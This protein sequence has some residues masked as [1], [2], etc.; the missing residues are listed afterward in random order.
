M[1]QGSTDVFASPN[2][3]PEFGRVGVQDPADLC[4]HIELVR[5]LPVSDCLISTVYGDLQ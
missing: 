1:D 2:T 4:S 3:D 5:I